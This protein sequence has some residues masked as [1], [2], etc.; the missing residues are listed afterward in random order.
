MFYWVNAFSSPEGVPGSHK[1]MRARVARKRMMDHLRR[2]ERDVDRQRKEAADG[3][4]F[5][6][7]RLC[8]RIFCRGCF[9][10]SRTDKVAPLG[11][12]VIHTKASVDS[13]EGW[14]RD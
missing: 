7:Y 11:A 2:V 8:S 5:A 13:N 10:A 1:R 6:L 9:N 4:G 3:R 14:A 12:M